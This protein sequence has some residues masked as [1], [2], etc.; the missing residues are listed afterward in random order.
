MKNTISF[1]IIKPESRRMLAM[2]LSALQGQAV[3]FEVSQDYNIV[4]ITIN[5]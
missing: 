2:I 1:D 4:F 3:N 5:S